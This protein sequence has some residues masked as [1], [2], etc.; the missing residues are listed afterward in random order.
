MNS[1]ADGGSQDG[2]TPVAER[3]REGLLDQTMDG[4]EVPPEPGERSIMTCDSAKRVLL[5]IHHVTPCHDHPV[6]PFVFLA[7]VTKRCSQ[8]HLLAL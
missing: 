8:R 5:H 4:L 6:R 1:P 2:G 7:M 3:P